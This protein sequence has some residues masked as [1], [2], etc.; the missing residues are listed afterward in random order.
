MIGR[1]QDWVFRLSKMKEKAILD[2]ESEE[3]DRGL[4]ETNGDQEEVVSG[5][6]KGRGVIEFVEG[7]MWL[8]LRRKS[9][10]NPWRWFRPRK[11]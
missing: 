5:N 1:G 4:G 6:E 2:S 8:R 7:A 3:D 9:L 10:P 11:E